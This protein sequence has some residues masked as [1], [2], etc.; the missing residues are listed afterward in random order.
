MAVSAQPGRNVLPVFDPV[1]YEDVEHPGDEYADD[2]FEQVGQLLKSRAGRRAAR[3]AGR[4]AD[5][6]RAVAVGRA[7]A[8]Y[9]KKTQDRSRVFDGFFIDRGREANGTI[10]FVSY[11]SVPTIFGLTENEAQP[12]QGNYGPMAR[13]WQ[14]AG[15]GHV[16]N[17]GDT[18]AVRNLAARRERP[19]SRRRGIPR[20][21]AAGARWA[22]APAS[23]AW[24]PGAP[25]ANQ[26]PQRYAKAAALFQL[27]RWI[28]TGRPAD[29]HPLFEFDGP[30]ADGPRHRRQRRRRPSPAADR[31]AR[32]PRTTAAARTRSRASRARSPTR[33]CSRAIPTSGDY[34][35]KMVAA[36]RGRSPREIVRPVRRGRHLPARRARRGPLAGGRA[37]ARRAQPVLMPRE[38]RRHPPAV[39]PPLRRPPPLPDPVAR[40]GR[41]DAELG[42]RTHRGQACEDAPP[43]QPRHQ[44]DRPAPAARR[45]R[46]DH[47]HRGG[48]A[49]DA[50]SA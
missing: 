43:P 3:T 18:Y 21:R 17:W 39:R 14:I 5:R 9:T 22:R 48:D 31:G 20:R 1:R 44:A 37:L 25:G 24:S 11:P 41:R 13:V 29:R 28:R 42:D 19:R 6:D 34:R 7:A 40:A 36:T 15:A 46:E 2:I 26:L 27:N 50:R 45:A 4:G 30:D 10:P 38:H 16:D 47:R 35:A 23:A 49:T 12:D 33:T 8:R 32:S